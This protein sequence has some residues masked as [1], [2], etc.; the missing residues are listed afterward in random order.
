MNVRKRV[1]AGIS[2]TL[3]LITLM[4]TSA[5]QAAD[6]NINV[7]DGSGNA[8]PADFGFR[9]IMQ[10]DTTWA[11]DPNKNLPTLDPPSAS[12]SRYLKVTESAVHS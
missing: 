2:L 10:E 4:T 7:V 8:L 1:G 5:V 11:V 9:W 6:F 3:M 12:S